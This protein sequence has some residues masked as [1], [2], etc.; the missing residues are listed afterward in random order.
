MPVRFPPPGSKGGIVGYVA[1][2][3]RLPSTNGSERQVAPVLCSGRAGGQPEKRGQVGASVGDG[4]DTLP[5]VAA[6]VADPGTGVAAPLHD[7]V[8][9]IL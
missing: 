9:D 2:R 6:D 1:G 8:T 3:R 4:F 5:P 7:N